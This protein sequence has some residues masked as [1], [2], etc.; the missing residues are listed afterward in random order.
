MSKYILHSF[1]GLANN[2]TACGKAG[3]DY[4]DLGT[5]IRVRKRN[6][7]EIFSRLSK[8]REFVSRKAKQQIYFRCETKR[9]HC[10]MMGKV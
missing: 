9:K 5:E 2:H 6:G 3:F 7:S 1:S 8:H 4:K 10:K